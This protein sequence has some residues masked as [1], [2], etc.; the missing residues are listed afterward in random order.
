MCKWTPLG[1]AVLRRVVGV[2]ILKG[3]EIL[4]GVNGKR[5][6]LW[7]SSRPSAINCFSSHLLHTP[8]AHLVAVVELWPDVVAKLVI[9][10][11]IRHRQLGRVWVGL[12]A[13]APCLQV[14]Y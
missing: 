13:G 7:E 4:K 11:L 2:K 14:V 6:R 1:L 5:P 3:V 12:E 10:P 9:Q 8:P